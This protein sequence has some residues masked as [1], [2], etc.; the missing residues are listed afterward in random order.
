MYQINIL[1]T[2]NLYKV[3]YQFYLNKNIKVTIKKKKEK[4]YLN[5]SSTL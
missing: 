4:A 2:S 1:H 3:T 5:V